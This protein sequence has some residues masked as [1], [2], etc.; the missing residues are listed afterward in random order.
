MAENQNPEAALE[1]KRT[2]DFK[3]LYCNNVR[4]ESSVWDL[5]ALFGTLD[6]GNPDPSTSHPGVRFHTGVTMPWAQ[7][8]IALY[9]LYIAILFQEQAN[10]T[11]SVPAAIRPPKV[12]DVIPEFLKQPTGQEVA[13]KADAFRTFV[14]GE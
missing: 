9:N 2:A 7:A 3:D 10:G 4:F 5:K 14:F 8:K 1:W 11:V 13:D 6:Q 12:R